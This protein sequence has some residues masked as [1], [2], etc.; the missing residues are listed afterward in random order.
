MFFTNNVRA[1]FW[2]EFKIHPAFLE[3]F[4]PAETHVGVHDRVHEGVY[5]LSQTELKIINII[6]NQLINSSQIAAN[7][8]YKTLTRNVKSALRTLL[9][10]NLI[11]Y[12]IPEKPRSKRQ[13]YRITPMG[14]STLE[15]CRFNR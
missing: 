2:V 3:Q 1:S 13:Q 11:A 9:E 5:D 6:N 4:I 10:K 8:G 12:T 14:K 7:F 15:K